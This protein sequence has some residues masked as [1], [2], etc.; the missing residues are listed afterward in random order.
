MSGCPS[1]HLRFGRSLYVQVFLSVD[2]VHDSAR[3]GI[4]AKSFDALSVSVAYWRF[5]NS[6]AA[7]VTPTVGF[8]LSR[9][10]WSPTLSVSGLAPSWPDAVVTAIATIAAAP[11]AR[12]PGPFLYLSRR[13]LPSL[14]MRAI[15][16]TPV[17]EC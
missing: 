4:G 6:Y 15:I 3:P 10:C 12:R 8:A 16:S 14:R 5:Q 11:P 13:A 2:D 7:T 1:D 17:G 9:S